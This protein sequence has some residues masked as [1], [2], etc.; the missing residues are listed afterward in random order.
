MPE[1]DTGEA[2]KIFVA[3]AEA[4]E[5]RDLHTASHCER[6]SFISVAM[7]IACGLERQDLLI[8]YR[9]GYMHD[10]GKIG[11][12]D[13]ILFKPGKLT[14]EEW[15]VMRTHTTRGVEICRHMKSLAPVIPIIRHHHEHWDGSGYPD[16]LVGEDTPLLARL[17]QIGDIYDALT[18][19]RP[20]KDPISPAKALRIIR[21]ETACGWRDPRIVEIFFKL[22]KDVISK[23]GRFVISGDRSLDAMR[24]ALSRMQL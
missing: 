24:A 16:G 5:Q 12:P 17:L 20:Y 15:D 22:H 11:I 23:A 10:I 8:L 18:S 3:L 9:G 13:S 7:G 21:E 14:P 4:V 6:L 1:S 2:D 19:A